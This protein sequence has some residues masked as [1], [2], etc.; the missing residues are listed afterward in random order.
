MSISRDSLVINL[1]IAGDNLNAHF[2]L[3]VKKLEKNGTKSFQYP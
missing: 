3:T 1:K 2:S